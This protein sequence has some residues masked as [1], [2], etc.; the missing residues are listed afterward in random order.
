ML[1][2]STTGFCAPAF[3]G[4]L[5]HGS[6]AELQEG[7]RVLTGGNKDCVVTPEAL[8]GVMET[9]GVHTSMEELLDL[10]KIVHQD[11][12]SSDFTFNE[13]LT[14]MTGEVSGKMENELLSAF[15]SCDK[16]KSGYISK[17][18]FEDIF[19]SHGEKS[20]PQELQELL[21]FAASSEE[22][23]RIDYRKFLKELM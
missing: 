22:D 19:R 7:F 15:E 14:L 4:P 8:L 5:N 23:D 1:P 9:V 6:I 18:K 21:T 3:R 10:L 12:E 20:D 2:S 11:E 16:T 17:E 13:F